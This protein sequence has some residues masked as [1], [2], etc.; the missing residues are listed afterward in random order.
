MRA[1]PE[2][3]I[4]MAP[5][6]KFGVSR[7]VI[8]ST[9]EQAVHRVDGVII[10]RSGRLLVYDTYYYQILFR[11]IRA[12]PKQ[13]MQGIRESTGI[14]FCNKTITTYLKLYYIKYWKCKKC[15]H[16]TP[17]KNSKKIA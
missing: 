12:N 7:G 2:W 11:Y 4:H 17:K 13:S 10:A 9:L 14:S 16:L 6:T 1:S 3:A 8:R 15:P 5:N